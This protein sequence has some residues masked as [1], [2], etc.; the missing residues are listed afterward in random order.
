MNES[1]IEWKIDPE[2]N[3]RYYWRQDEHGISSKIVEITDDLRMETMKI[4][5]NVTWG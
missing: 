1:V 2:T 3:K 5:M 4:N